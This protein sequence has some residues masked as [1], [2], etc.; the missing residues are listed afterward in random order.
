LDEHVP[1]EEDVTVQKLTKAMV[2]KHMIKLLG[3]HDEGSGLMH[4]GRHRFRR[5]QKRIQEEYDD[6][7][8]DVVL[9]C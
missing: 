5:I 7:D 1:L 9:I 8:H 4:V 2:W 3:E 6:Y